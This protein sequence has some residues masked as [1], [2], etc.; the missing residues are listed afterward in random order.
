MA[1]KATETIAGIWFMSERE[2][3]F[4]TK[5]MKKHLIMSYLKLSYKDRLDLSIMS[6]WKAFGDII[7]RDVDHEDFH[8]V[9]EEKIEE[10]KNLNYPCFKTADDMMNYI[11]YTMN[12]L[13]ELACLMHFN[14]VKTEH[15]NVFELA[16]K[17][18]TMDNLKSSEKRKKMISAEKEKNKKQ[19]FII[20]EEKNLVVPDN[21]LIKKLNSIKKR[22]E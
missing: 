16:Q 3:R 9:Y 4:E 7:F 14:L 18:A 1:K 15:F 5:K 12:S 6:C 17:R 8:D 13:I 11:G 20:P 21:T 19:N 10:F 2:D 22:A